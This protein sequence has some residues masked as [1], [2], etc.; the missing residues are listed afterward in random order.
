M[1]YLLLFHYF[2]RL[3]F[4]F[5]SFISGFHDI[6]TCKH[7]T[8]LLYFYFIHERNYVMLHLHQVLRYEPLQN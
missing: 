1:F 8:Y 7:P 4:T 3:L 5:L 2:E 6:L